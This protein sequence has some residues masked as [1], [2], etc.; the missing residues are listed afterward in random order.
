MALSVPSPRLVD[1]H[2]RRHCIHAVPLR[3]YCAR[4]AEAARFDRDPHST[5]AQRVDTK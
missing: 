4:C 2:F 5:F 1:G 3:A